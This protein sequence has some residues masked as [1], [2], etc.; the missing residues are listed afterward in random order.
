MEDLSI[1]PYLTDV[2]ILQQTADQIKKDF[3]FF[4]LKITFSGN[5][6]E[7]YSE[8]FDQIYPHLKKLMDTNYEKFFSL[9]YRIDLNE[10]QIHKVQTDNKNEEPAKI[11]SDLIIKRCLQKVIL[12]KLYSK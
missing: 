10:K 8:L 5:K 9:L 4:S 3:S 1:Q 11:I 6:N 12:R 2:H 7:A